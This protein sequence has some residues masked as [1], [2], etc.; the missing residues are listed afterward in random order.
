MG[1]S[2]AGQLI[3]IRRVVVLMQA[4][5]IPVWLRPTSRHSARSSSTFAKKLGPRGMK[6][7]VVTTVPSA[8]HR[9]PRK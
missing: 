5:D 1:A 9:C 6:P 4:A 7:A 8:S 3:L 2:T